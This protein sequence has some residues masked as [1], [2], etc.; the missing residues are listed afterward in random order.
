MRFFS[1]IFKPKRK[2]IVETQLG[3]FA[4]TYSRGDKNIWTNNTGEFL[5]SVRGTDIE[6]GKEQ[7]GFLEK[8]DA[9]IQKLDE[10]ITKRFI[11]EFTE[12]GLKTNFKHW[13]ERFKIV[14]TEVMIIF[15]EEAFWNIT[16][17]DLKEP[18]A[19]FTLY[20][21]GL[22]TTDFSIDT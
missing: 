4:L 20:I 7:L 21:E 12:A 22:K 19:H 11:K 13:K 9:E 6:P 16:F 2:I 5:I 15:Q 14:A 17:E 1:N 3:D 18:Y 8:V 10:K